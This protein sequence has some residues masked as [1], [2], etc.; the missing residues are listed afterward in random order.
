[1]FAGTWVLQEWARR[2]GNAKWKPGGLRFLASEGLIVKV[3]SSRGGK[4]A[5]YRMLDRPTMRPRCAS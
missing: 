2:T 4:R 3:D 5:Y 1:M